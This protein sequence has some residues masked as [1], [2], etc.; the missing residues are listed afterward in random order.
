MFSLLLSSQQ[1]LAC[2][3]KNPCPES[4]IRKQ[5]E[6]RNIIPVEQTEKDNTNMQRNGNLDRQPLSESDQCAPLSY[7]CYCGRSESKFSLAYVKC[8][9]CGQIMHG[10]CAG[11]MSQEDLVSNSL[12]GEPRI[13]DERHCLFC[14]HQL[15]Q[16]NSHGLI[17]SRATL[18]VTPPSIL[19]QWEREIRRHT[20]LRDINVPNSIGRPL[21]VIVYPGVKAIC[22]SSHG[23]AT[24]SNIMQLLQ[25][26]HLA[27]AD[28]KKDSIV[29]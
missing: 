18:I 8:S 7:A 28:G 22:S 9:R 26:Y 10:A 17:G 5:K 2:I 27:D 23:Q 21:K 13:C 24:Q 11:Y 20:S 14:Q 3:L 4:Y 1:L 12:S 25:P 16:S 19:N 29:N 6:F 15:G